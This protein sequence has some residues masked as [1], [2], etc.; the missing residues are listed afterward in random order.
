MTSEPDVQRS[1]AA[2][3]GF[4]KRAYRES[5]TSED[6]RRGLAQEELLRRLIL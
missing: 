3:V 5:F 4:A 2:Q 6:G 1:R